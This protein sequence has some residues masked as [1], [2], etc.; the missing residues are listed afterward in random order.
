MS[1]L[2]HC[3]LGYS[4]KPI[5]V[6]GEKIMLRIADTAGEDQFYTFDSTLCDDASV[7]WCFECC[8]KDVQRT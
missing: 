4:T 8:I 5:T 2:V 3:H 1:V 6:D 7:S